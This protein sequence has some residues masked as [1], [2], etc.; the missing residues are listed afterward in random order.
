MNG[1]PRTRRS[2]RWTF[3]WKEFVMNRNRN[4]V[5]PFS[6]VFKIET[7]FLTSKC[8][9]LEEGYQWRG[10]GGGTGTLPPSFLTELNLRCN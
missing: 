3:R 1:D 8:V 2:L 4:D 7:D 10:Q 5:K 9:G 6:E